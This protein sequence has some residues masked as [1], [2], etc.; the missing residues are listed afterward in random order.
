VAHFLAIH[1][2]QAL[3]L[4][5]WGLLRAGAAVPRAWLAAGTLGWVGLTLGAFALAQAGVPL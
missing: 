1:A 3:P 5:A 2:M 4:L